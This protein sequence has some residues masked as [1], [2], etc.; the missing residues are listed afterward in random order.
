MNLMKLN[1]FWNEVWIVG[2]W[3]FF[4]RVKVNSFIS[5]YAYTS[6]RTD[7]LQPYWTHTSL[8]SL[9]RE[10]LACYGVCLDSHWLIL[11]ITFI[12]TVSPLN[13]FLGHVYVKLQWLWNCLTIYWHKHEEWCPATILNLHIVEV[14]ERETSHMLR[15]LFGQ[16]MTIFLIAFFYGVYN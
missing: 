1:N 9:Q 15:V 13:Y 8:K 11:L 3:N 7:V 10:L 2:N 14:S 16:S 4:S 6:M 5:P 12:Y